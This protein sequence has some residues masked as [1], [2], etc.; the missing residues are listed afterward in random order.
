MVKPTLQEKLK[1]A[2]DFLNGRILFRS[3]EIE[4]ALIRRI[5][6][7]AEYSDPIR[8]AEH[9]LEVTG[10][11]SADQELHHRIWAWKKLQ[12]FATALEGNPQAEL[13]YRFYIGTG[14]D[15]N[16]GEPLDQPI[17]EFKLTGNTAQL[18]KT[19]RVVEAVI[20]WQPRTNGRV[21][22]FTING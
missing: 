22:S 15:Y 6:A 10:D 20:E 16:G 3:E 9:L 1:W 13:S 8:R 14:Y 18:L 11:I 12:E 21:A 4:K 2:I 7:V 5:T 17:D 19:L